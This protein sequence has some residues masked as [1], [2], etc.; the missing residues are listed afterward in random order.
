MGDASVSVSAP[1]NTRHQHAPACACPALPT[2]APGGFMVQDGI[3][4]IMRN[5]VIP[6]GVVI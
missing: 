2:L 1:C 3:V 6:D 4:V 5:A